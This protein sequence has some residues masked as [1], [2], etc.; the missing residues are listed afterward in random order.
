MLDIV[1]LVYVLHNTMNVLGN[2]LN[3]SLNSSMKL[4]YFY[5]AISRSN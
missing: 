4:Q 5:E 3:L 2:I 1:L